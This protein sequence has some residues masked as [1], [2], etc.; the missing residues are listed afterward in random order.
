MGEQIAYTLRYI[1]FL[2][3]VLLD[4]SRVLFYSIFLDFLDLLFAFGTTS[5]QKPDTLP[6]DPLNAEN[7]FLEVNH[8]YSRYIHTSPIEICYQ[9]Q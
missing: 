8:T 9:L 1:V 6:V 2:Q 4:L 3:R 7:T 5:E